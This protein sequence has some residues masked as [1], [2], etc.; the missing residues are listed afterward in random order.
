LIV[1]GTLR[2]ECEIVHRSTDAV[3]V[4]FPAHEAFRRK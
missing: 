2:S 3:G 4:R 1:E